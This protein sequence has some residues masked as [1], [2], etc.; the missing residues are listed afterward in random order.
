MI[1]KH[2]SVLSCIKG[3]Q[4]G[5][6]SHDCVCHLANLCLFQGI[7]CLSVKVDDFLVDLFYYFDKSFKRKVQLREFKQFTGTQQLKF[8][9]HFKR[10]WLSLERSVKRVIQ[11][12]QALHAYLDKKSEEDK[13]ARVQCLNKHLESPLTKLVMHFV[14]YSLDFLCK[15]NAISQSDLSILPSLKVKVLGLLHILFR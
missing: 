10:R 11:Q 3:K 14:E 15:F 6:F 12:W 13:S 9:K 7:K 4:L 1:R 5:V 2:N 8:L